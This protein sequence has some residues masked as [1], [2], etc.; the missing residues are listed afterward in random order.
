MKNFYRQLLERDLRG[1]GSCFK[2]WTLVVFTL[3][4]S[5]LYF[6]IF[7]YDTTG[8]SVGPAYGTITPLIL[9]CLASSLSL[10]IW[11]Y[12]KKELWMEEPKD[13]TKVEVDVIEL[14]K[15]E[16]QSVNP[17]HEIMIDEK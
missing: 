12:A 17:L 6:F 2:N 5:S 7:L 15:S 10:G 8:D 4:F 11:H 16:F 3:Q 14:S 9:I 1:M 13:E